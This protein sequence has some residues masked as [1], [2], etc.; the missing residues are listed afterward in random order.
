MAK[1]K[2]Q[3]KSKSEA[4]RKAVQAKPKKASKA[5]AAKFICRAC[6]NDIPKPDK[7]RP[8]V[9]PI[10]KNPNVEEKPEE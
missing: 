6:A 2:S 10:C 4:R 9:C 8:H 5:K 3:S 1:T 7:E